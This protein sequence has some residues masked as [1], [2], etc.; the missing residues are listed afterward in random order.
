MLE[1]TIE[2]NF[3]LSETET[4]KVPYKIYNTIL[5]Y[6]YI[7]RLQSTVLE[8]ELDSDDYMLIIILPDYEFGLS[9]LMK[10]LQIGDNV[11]NLRDIVKQMTPSWVKTIV[12]KFNLK[13]NIILTSDL[14]NVCI[15]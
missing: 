13:G 8:L 10:L 2:H 5:K 4:V 1:D 14:Q 12:P 6:A 9:N 11:P 3:Y 7:E 15:T